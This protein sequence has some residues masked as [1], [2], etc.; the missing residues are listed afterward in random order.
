MS[1]RSTTPTS[2]CARTATSTTW[3]TSSRAAA[4]T[5][6]AS[7]P[8]TRSCG[9]RQPPAVMCHLFAL[10]RKLQGERQP[11]TGGCQLR[12]I[13]TAVSGDSGCLCLLS[14]DQIT[15]EELNVLDRLPHYCPVC[16]ESM[17]KVHPCL[18]ILVRLSHTCDGVGTCSVGASDT[19]ALCTCCSVP[20]VESGR[21]RRAD[22]AVS[23][24]AANLH[25]AEGAAFR[26]E[27]SDTSRAWPNAVYEVQE[28]LCGCPPAVAP[29]PTCEP[30]LLLRCH[31]PSA[32][33]VIRPNILRT[34]RRC[35]ASCQTTMSRSSSRATRPLW[36][37]S[38]TASTRHAA[39]GDLDLSDCCA[40]RQAACC[41]SISS[42]LPAADIRQLGCV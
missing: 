5:S 3:W 16:G 42:A 31:A 4:C 27:I 35:R 8:S 29:R 14:Q 30:S 41:V 11:E 40:V 20:R 15:L 13:A 22:L 6:P 28:D 25:K 33:H 36:R 18:P 19:V 38:A 7:T 24:P 2:R 26:A 1:T 10:V 39:A 34:L 23:G 37:T 32:L 21:P 12:C 17:A 9:S